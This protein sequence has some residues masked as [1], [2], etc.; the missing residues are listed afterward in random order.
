MFKTNRINKNDGR[1]DPTSS[2]VPWE[3]QVLLLNGVMLSIVR[4]SQFKSTFN[5]RPNTSPEKSFNPINLKLPLTGKY[6][7]LVFYSIK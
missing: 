5:E 7:M 6:L 4:Y 2:F 1:W 3:F